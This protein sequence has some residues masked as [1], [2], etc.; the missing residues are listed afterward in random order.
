MPILS[1]QSHVAYGHVGNAAA[2]FPLQRLGWDVWPVHTVLFSNHPGYGDFGGAV[3]PLTTVEAVL[4]GIAARGALSDC[5]AVLSGY[6]GQAAL[7]RAILDSVARTRAA[8]PGALYV[9]DPVMGDRDGGVYV[10]DDI[11][12]FMRASA[13]PAADIVLPNHFELELLTGGR[14]DTL[15]AAVKA[16]RALR[17]TGPRIVVVTSF[18]RADAPP[19]VVEMLLA[20]EQGTWLIETPRLAFPIAP[21][22]AGDLI[23]ALFTGHYL[24]LRD[25]VAALA[26]AVAAVYAVLD[27]TSRLGRRELALVAAQ[28]AL[29]DP[30]A[31]FIPRRIA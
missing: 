2:V 17:A 1:I 10:S 20:T 26:E 28:A 21:N 14:A 11:P 5:E 13:V 23:A 9:C 18:E 4:D 3:T 19:A 15:E 6:V 29:A 16:A 30:P 25:P 22:G 31:R 27:E 24:R 12:D 8:N 7:G